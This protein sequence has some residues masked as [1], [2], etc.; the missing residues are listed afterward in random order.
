M[1]LLGGKSANRSLPVFQFPVIA[2]QIP[3]RSWFER[4]GHQGQWSLASVKW[5][6]QEEGFS[7]SSHLI[8]GWDFFFSLC[9]I[10]S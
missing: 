1:H 2:M 3:C 8:G 9:P 4:S 10:G 5:T 7:F 6:R